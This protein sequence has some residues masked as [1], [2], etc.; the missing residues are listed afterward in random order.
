M[1]EI[2]RVETKTLY[3]S[4][5]VDIVANCEEIQK[6]PGSEYSKEQAKINAYNEIRDILY[7]GSV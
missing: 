3:F 6:E 7:G 1:I 2:S 4:Q 5:I